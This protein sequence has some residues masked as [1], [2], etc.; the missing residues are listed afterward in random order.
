MSFSNIHTHGLVRLACAAPRLK[1][2]DPAFNVAETLPMLRRAEEGGAS[3]VLFPELGLSAYAIDDLL[4]QGA[5]LDAVL[6]ALGELVEESRKLRAVAVVGA[7]LR[8]EGRLFNCAVAIHRGRILAVVPKTYLPNYREFYER[9]QFASGE[10]AGVTSIMLCGQEVPFGTDILLTASDV[11]D[12]TI[13]MEICEDV[14][15]PVPPSSFAALAGATVLLNLSASNVTI[16]KSDWRHALCKAHSG[17]C[18]AA[19]AYSA[20][21]PGESTTD[22]AWDGQAMIYESGVLLAEAARF[23]AEPQLILADI[24]IEGLALDRLRMNTFG[25][26]AD[27]LRDRLAFRRVE[28]ALEPDRE[29]D[30]GLRREVDRFPYVPNDD[31]RL[32]ELCFEA[33]NIQSHG[34]RKRLESARVDRIVIGVSGGLDSTQALLVAADTV[35][36]LG[37]PRSSILAYTLPAFATTAGTKGNAWKLMRALGVTAQEIDMTPACRQM[38]V[39]IGH[40]FARGEPVYDITFENVQAGA[41]TS[42]LFRLANRHNGLVLG[43]GDLSELALGWCT[44]GV[45]DHMSHYNV[46]GSVSKTL[47]QHLIRWVAGTDRFGAEVSATLDDILATEISPELVPGEGDEPAQKTEDFVGPYALQDFNLFYTTRYGFRP[48]KIAFLSQ[49][50]WADAARGDWP[51]HMEAAKKLA[52]DLPT[53]KKWLRV[54][55]RRF[56]ETSQFKRSAVPNGPKVSSGGSLSPRGDW[57]APSDASAAAW[58]ADL[59]RIAD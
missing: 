13:H 49:H 43:T 50:A 45:G 42:L 28:F 34:L 51:P 5:L 3:I 40:P 11:P 17:R 20:A 25:D 21:G 26:N 10:R 24:D 37:L 8:V 23:A 56:F 39:D 9:R 27:A 32:N 6:A 36:A 53:I 35:D 38:L 54:F 58:L 33:Y 47:I 57:R 46:N 30:L 7:P 44:Y 18:I 16:G 12:L 29:S 19:Y 31:A 1:V 2:A 22:L 41:R 52:Y 59:E 14:W 4:M 55:V 15:L 48:S